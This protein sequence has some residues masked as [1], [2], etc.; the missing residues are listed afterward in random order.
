MDCDDVTLRFCDGFR[1]TLTAPGGTVPVGREE[2]G[3]QPYNLL[4][5]ALGSC[6]YTTFLGVATK[7]RLAFTEARLTVSGH[8]RD[9]I[10]M[11]LDDVEIRMV[12]IGASDE[13][14]IRKSAELGAEYCSIHAT[15]SKVAKMRLSLEFR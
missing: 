5:G 4:L 11:T 13:E 8:K 1:G 9:E 10:P 2:G 15:I 14:G 6:F 3:L 12:V 7:K